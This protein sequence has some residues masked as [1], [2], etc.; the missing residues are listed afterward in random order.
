MVE[1][2]RVDQRRVKRVRKGHRGEG[3]VLYWM[4]RDQRVEDNWA[5]LQ[6]QDLALSVGR[7]LLVV[8]CLPGAIHTIGK[9]F[10]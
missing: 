2:F 7:P 4:N 6:S 3:P 8:F 1:R 5:L 10:N 9:F